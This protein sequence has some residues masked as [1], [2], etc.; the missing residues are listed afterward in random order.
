MPWEISMFKS[1][2]DEK[3]VGKRLVGEHPGVGEFS[4]SSEENISP[5]RV[6]NC[7]QFS[8]E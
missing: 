2:Q 3:D 4:E 8:Y 1:Q 7:V 5:N 6:V